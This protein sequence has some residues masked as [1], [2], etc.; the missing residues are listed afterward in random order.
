MWRAR[1]V[2][3]ACGALLLVSGCTPADTDP[4]PPEPSPT[5]QNNTSDVGQSSSDDDAE[6]IGALGPASEEFDP[7]VFHRAA[8]YHGLIQCQ[9][10]NGLILTA[11]EL[12]AVDESTDRLTL[13]YSDPDRSTTRGPGVWVEPTE[14]A[15]QPAT[16]EELDFDGEAIASFSIVGVSWKPGRDLGSD[17]YAPKATGGPIADVRYFEGSGGGHGLYVGFT[18][19]DARIRTHTE[20]DPYRVVI[21]VRT[22]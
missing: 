21:E 20:T 10:S 6:Y 2:A 4:T 5:S 1:F 9:M 16:G 13:E 8:D 12:E 18:S 14:S 19:S 17:V 11:I 15:R 22:P 7:D 3:A